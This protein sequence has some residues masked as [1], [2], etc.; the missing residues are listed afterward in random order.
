[1]NGRS[2]RRGTVTETTQPCTK[3][4]ESLAKGGTGK[5]RDRICE[6]GKMK[7]GQVT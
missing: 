1:M 7:G 3:V 2:E 5:E 6:G 4:W